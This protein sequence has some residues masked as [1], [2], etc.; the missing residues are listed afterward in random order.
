MLLLP[1][2]LTV[3]VKTLAATRLPAKTLPAKTLPAANGE[4]ARA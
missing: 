3:P 1:A 4:K 2:A